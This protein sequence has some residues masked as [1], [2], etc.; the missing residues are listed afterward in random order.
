MWGV[1]IGYL[2]S[3]QSCISMQGAA[4]MHA[5]LETGQLLYLTGD[6]C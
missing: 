3:K 4:C 5:F 6:W 1:V 2:T